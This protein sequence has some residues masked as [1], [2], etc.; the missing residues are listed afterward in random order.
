MSSISKYD[1]AIDTVRALPK[2][3]PARMTLPAEW[4]PQSGV[5]LTWPRP[6]SAWGQKTRAVE[7]VFAEV[8]ACISRYEG[9]LITCLDPAHRAHV[10]GLLK[11]AGAEMDAFRF[12]LAPSN[13]VWARDHGPITV[14]EDL[15][16]VLLDFVF[17]G[18]GGKYP[19]DLDDALT[20]VLHSRGAF[21]ATPIRRIDFV[22]EGGGIDTDGAGTLLTTSSCLLAPGRNPG[23]SRERF[24]RE[25][26]AAM[27]ITRV[28]WL[29]HG[30]L[31]GDD[32]DGHVDML[33]R[34]CDEHT[35]AHVA[36]DDRFDEHFD[37]LQAMGRELAGFRDRRGQ[38]YRLI[39]LPLPKPK[40]DERGA[41]LPAS[42]A[43][44]L[45]IN[46][47]VLVPLYDDPADEI[48]AARLRACFPGRVIIGIRCLPL[49]AQY[50]SLHCV[51]MQLPRGVLA[52]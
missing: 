25:F 36:C 17:N 28:L 6:D 44:F 7:R 35:I 50:G 26:R 30:Y 39:P 48:A 14:F 24:E 33:A 41:R 12:Y 37:A 49:I 47:A 20:R 42:Y 4:A 3:F 52:P 13:D 46:G 19:A 34:F 1:Y 8:A 51:T 11:E 45:I 43:N 40:L 5:M 38:P 32:T 15:R 23:W 31:A 16:P 27:G 2:E 10:E 21:G 29:D 18:W 9:V 22:L